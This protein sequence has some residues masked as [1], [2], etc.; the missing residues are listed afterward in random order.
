[1]K[2]PEIIFKNPVKL[3]RLF[4][5]INLYGKDE[6]SYELRKEQMK[7]TAPLSKSGFVKDGNAFI[8]EGIIDTANFHQ[9]GVILLVD[10]VSDSEKEIAKKENH[11]LLTAPLWRFEVF[12]LRKNLELFLY[13]NE[14]QTGIPHREHFKLAALKEGIPLEIK[15]NGKFDFTMTAGKQRTFKEQQFIIEYLGEFQK[16]SI[17]K[18]PFSPVK[19]DIPEERKVIDLIKPLW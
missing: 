6:K 12:E 19:K 3:I 4:K 13:Y 11:Y 18:E 10:D 2:H 17:L 1:M 9:C 5:K 15:I 14:Y 7:W 16:L 8:P